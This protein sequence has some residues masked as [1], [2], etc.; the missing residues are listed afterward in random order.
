M[1]LGFITTVV[2]PGSRGESRGHVIIR[3]RQ[4]GHHLPARKK[5]ALS[6]TTGSVGH[7]SIHPSVLPGH[8]EEDEGE[9]LFNLFL[10]NLCQV[11]PVNTVNT[12]NT[13]PVNTK[14]LSFTL[15]SE[16]VSSKRLG[17]M[18]RDLTRGGLR[19]DV[20]AVS[21]PPPSQ[22]PAIGPQ[23]NEQEPEAN[24]TV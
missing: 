19:E 15:L 23:V 20:R 12:V 5:P 4:R 9:L 17:I 6:G 2:P 21:M 24:E 13:G 11:C 22:D 10:L 16:V 3:R 8:P 18:A 1:L 7:P 14:Q